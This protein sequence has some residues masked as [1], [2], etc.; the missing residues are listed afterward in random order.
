MRNPADK[1]QVA[2]LGRYIYPDAPK[3]LAQAFEDATNAKPFSY[4]LLNLH[5]HS[6]DERFRL[7]TGIFSN[8]SLYVYIPIKK[9]KKTYK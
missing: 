3:F 2:I 6:T 5:P 7:C 4:I 1:L 9:H 8:E